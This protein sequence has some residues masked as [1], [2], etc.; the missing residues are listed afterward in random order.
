M[1]KEQE[2][3]LWKARIA[4]ER[5]QEMQEWKMISEEQLHSQIS[6]LQLS[7]ERQEKTNIALEEHE[8]QL[9]IEIANLRAV[10]DDL[11]NS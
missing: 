3:L 1:G 10:L 6:R 2:E 5:A 7:I 11:Q 8:K 4:E 9:D